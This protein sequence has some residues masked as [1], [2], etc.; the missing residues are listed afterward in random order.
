MF[1]T[2]PL[3]DA[4]YLS[5]ADITV[6][7][8]GTSSTKTY[9]I[10]QVLNT[11][12]IENNNAIITVAGQ[13]I[14]NLKV[15]AM[16]D[17]AEIV[18][19]SPA[20]KSVITSFNKSDRVY[21][22][23]TGSRIE[24]NS[25]D[26]AQDA[27]SGKRNILFVNEANG[28]PLNIYNELAFRTI[29]K[30]GI[31]SRIF[32]DYNPNAEFWVHRELVGKKNVEL[33]I[34]DHRHNPFLS[35][36]DHDKIEAIREKD[37]ELWKVYA[38]GLT[39]RIEGVVFRNYKI[40]PAIPPDA[41]FIGYGLDFGFTNDPTALIEVYLHSGELWINELIYETG[42]TNQDISQRMKALGLMQARETV[43]DS[44]EPKSIEELTRLGWNVRGASKGP[45]SIKNSIDI[46]KRYKL[47]ITQRS[48]NLKKEIVAYRYKSRKDGTLENSPVDCFNHGIDALRYLALNKLS[49]NR[50]QG[51]YA[52][53]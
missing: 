31:R 34:S 41:K 6:N 25:Y 5:E 52:V 47:N 49:E 33:I 50:G 8:G 17:Q 9:S 2:S 30:N 27:K 28:I 23:K 45:D 22:F 1:K 20:L 42:L 3:F 39:G 15:G 46:L 29:D 13:D 18:E 10:M 36:K 14:P 43:A 24:F 26:N 7:Q 12:A 37:E 40:V 16:R 11:L 53:S 38:R 35:Q 4:N 44:A 51:K 32:L 48:H 21:H 19:Q